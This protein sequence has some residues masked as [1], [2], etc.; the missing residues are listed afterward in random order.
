MC[1]NDDDIGDM[2]KSAELISAPDPARM[3]T[4]NG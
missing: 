3:Q 2:L 4:A 1:A